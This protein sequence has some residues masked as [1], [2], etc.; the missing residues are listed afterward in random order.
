MRTTKFNFRTFIVFSTQDDLQTVLAKE[1]LKVPNVTLL[2][3]TLK[4][5]FTRNLKPHYGTSCST[6][7]KTTKCKKFV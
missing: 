5:V 7:N 4:N 1:L 6:E 2:Y 3:R